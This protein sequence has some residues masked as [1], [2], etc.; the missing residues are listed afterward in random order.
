MVKYDDTD[1]ILNSQSP[2]SA[3]SSSSRSSTTSCMGY[4]SASPPN[5][6]ICLTN[7]DEICFAD[8][9]LL[10]GISTTTDPI[11]LLHTAASNIKTTKKLKKVNIQNSDKINN[12]NN[13]TTNRSSGNKFIFKIFNNLK[14]ILQVQINWEGHIVPV[15]H[16]QW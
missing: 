7:K 8:N 12:Y 5:Y 10:N 13:N 11:P 2:L 1:F 15:C 6:F 4:D 9:S 14:L 3:R 16:Y